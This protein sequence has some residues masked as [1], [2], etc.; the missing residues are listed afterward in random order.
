VA[1]HQIDVVDVTP[2][3]AQE[4][5]AAGLLA[6]ER[7]RPGIVLTGGEAIGNRVWQALAGQPGIDAY[8]LYG[9]TECTVD[10]LSSRI[11]GPR[12]RIGRPL[13]NLRAYLLDTDMSPVP[14]GVTGELYLAGAQLARGYLNRPGLTAQRFVADPFGAPGTRMYRTGDLARWDRDGELEYLGR[15]DQQ[16]KVRGFRIEPGEVEAA[17]LRHPA[18][19]KAAVVAR[20]DHRGAARLVAYLAAAASEPGPAPG[21]L[22]E[23][24]AGVHDPR[25][26]RHAG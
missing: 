8:N 15:A 18:V 3:Y 13:A 22:R 5:L 10:A 26:V 21:E 23:L 4:L 6:G 2:A 20:E 12:P 19:R 16:V 7:H 1:G 14:F 24:L 9:P 11:T 17:L 25:G